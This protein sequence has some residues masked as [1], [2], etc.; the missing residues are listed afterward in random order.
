MRLLGLDIGTTGCKALLV[1]PDKGVVARAFREYGIDTDT[2][3][4]AEQDA[5]LVWNLAKTVMREALE[6]DGFR[7]VSAVSVSAQG[8]AAILVDGAGVPIYPAVLGMDYR[9]QAELPRIAERFDGY[10]LFKRTGMRPHPINSFIKVLWLQR[11]RPE[12]FA[13]AEKIR[14]YSDFI[15]EKLGCPDVV[16]ASMASRSMAYNLEK[17]GWDSDILKTFGISETLFST[18]VPSGSQVGTMS[19]SLAQELGLKSRPVVVAG[20]HDQPVCA[21]GSG[22]ITDDIAMASTGTA[23][24][25]GRYMSSPLLSRGMYD[26]Y[27]PCYCSAMG[28]GYFTFAL[29]HTGGLALR[30]FRDQWSPEEVRQA[31]EQGRDPYDLIVEKMPA[32]PSNMFVMPHFNGSGTPYCDLSSRAAFVGMT[33]ATTRHEAGL[34]ILEGL[35]YELRINIDRMRELDMPVHRLRCVGGGSRS[36]RWLQLKASIL[37]MPV[38]VMETPDAGGLG[39]AILAGVGAEIFPSVEDGVHSLVKT[40]DT[41]F[42]EPEL[43]GRYEERYAIYKDL[44]ATLAPINRRLG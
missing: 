35:S 13:K 17:N 18:V 42:P 39:A 21:V 38:D 11:H 1:D 30:W 37:N 9:P 31:N 29:N 25:L 3:G 8:D 15:L 32:G 14:T 36:P 26:S 22:S 41:Y 34:A 33:L 12:I 2:C 6:M 4:K 16:D 28:K 10:E 23:E 27:Y 43:S 40:A 20:G 24:V 19:A 5:E 44:H 7:D